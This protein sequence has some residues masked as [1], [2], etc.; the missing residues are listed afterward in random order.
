MDFLLTEVVIKSLHSI[1]NLCNFNKPYAAIIVVLILI[2]TVN[3]TSPG[4][5]TYCSIRAKLVHPSG[6]T[7]A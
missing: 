4:S 2:S 6:V 1:N 7:F 3:T 5:S